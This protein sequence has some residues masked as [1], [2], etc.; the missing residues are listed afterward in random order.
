MNAT[1]RGLAA[2]TVL[3]AL[4]PTAGCALE[5]QA[6]GRPG[7]QTA[8]P[9]AVASPTRTPAGRAPVLSFDFDDLGAL[10]SQGV[11]SGELRVLNAGSE[12]VTVRVSG[13]GGGALRSM[14]DREGGFALRFPVYGR[15][16]G[17][18]MVLTATSESVTDPL[19]P[20]VADFSFGAD[21]AVDRVTE[22]TGLD[23]GNNLIQ[24][25]LSGDAGQ[26]KLQIDRGRASCLVAGD[27]GD[28]LVQTEQRIRPHT[29]YHAS[30]SRTG[31]VVTLDLGTYQGA[32]E[33]AVAPG[34]T[35]AVYLP[36]AT[37]LVLGGKATPG[38]VAVVGDSDQFN[39]AL[40]NVFLTIDRGS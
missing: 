20:G 1:S 18:R 11:G 40:D 38:G 6:A 24:R 13:A 3:V 27:A 22:G 28:V 26:Y 32:P 9:S 29:W 7:P 2:A 35:G 21:F 30:C 36:A 39:G 37:P 23:N 34:P 8:T 10:R 14:P 16:S 17:E 31:G 5:E 19:S 33:R 12:R 4:S 25:G 15:G